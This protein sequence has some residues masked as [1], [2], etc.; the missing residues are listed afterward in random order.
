[1]KITI[2]QEKIDTSGERKRQEIMSLHVTNPLIYWGKIEEIENDDDPDRRAQDILVLLKK[3]HGLAARKTLAPFNTDA[4]QRLD[5]LARRFPNFSEPV[6]RI[7]EIFR[8]SR[9]VD[10]R[11]AS[12]PPFLLVGEPGS[13][14]T[15]FAKQLAHAMCPG[16]VELSVSTMHGSFELAG[17][18]CGY[19]S[20]DA[21]R[22]TKELAAMENANPCFILDEVDK[23]YSRSGES[24]Y[25]VLLQLLEKTA[26]SFF[27]NGLEVEI[28]LSHVNYIATANSLEA[29]PDPLVSRFFVIHVDYPREGPEMNAVCRSIWSDLIQGEP[30]GCRFDAQLSG[31]VLAILDAKPPRAVRQTL[32]CA[33]ARAAR[34]VE[35]G[36]TET[37]VLW[38]GDL[39]TEADKPGRQPVGFVV[40]NRTPWNP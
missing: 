17:L 1:M 29:I 14:K 39:R 8:L 34:R 33:A 18:T 15:E 26:S 4:E 35:Q 30:W 2:D 23:A 9:L 31:D 5:E 32:M 24:V 19:T 3:C 13:G 22:L 10:T 37:L 21:G 38:P 6:A 11:A 12:F 20:G 16:V 27:D 36:D 40:G 25:N 28:D 7:Q